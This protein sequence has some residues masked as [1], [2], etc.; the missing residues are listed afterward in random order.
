M[1]KLEFCL[2][3]VPA[4]LTLAGCATLRTHQ[5]GV[6]EPDDL[7][8]DSEGAKRAEALANY[9]Q[10]Q[11]HEVH[12]RSEDALRHYERALE[13]DPTRTRLA[14]GM[15][16]H[17]LRIGNTEKATELLETAHAS[18]P[19]SYELTRALATLYANA[20]RHEEA[21][22]TYKQA[23]R[24]RRRDSEPYIEL[25]RY[26]M[27]QRDER[28]ALR[29]LDRGLRRVRDPIELYRALADI[30]MRKVVQSESEQQ[31]TDYTEVIA[32]Y[33]RMVQES[34][35]DDSIN[36]QLGELYLLNG[37]IPEAIAAFRK[38]SDEKPGYFFLRAVTRHATGRRKK[39][40]DLLEKAAPLLD[41]DPLVALALGELSEDG[42]DTQKAIRHFERARQIAPKQMAAYVRLA[43]LY[44]K[45][46][47]DKAAE[48]LSKAVQELPDDPQPRIY[49][50]YI[51]SFAKDYPGAIAEFEKA[52]ALLSGKDELLVGLGPMFYFWY[53]AACEREKQ[54]ERAEKLFEKCI[55]L[56]P[57]QDEAYNYLAYMWAERAVKLDQAL[58]YV[59][60]AL[61][62]Q[63]ENGAY[64]D[65]LG[66][67]YYQRK[68][69]EKAREQ[70]LKAH[71]LMKN[72]PTIAD[73]L[74][75]VLL[76]LEGPSQA[77]FFWEK[78]LALDPKNER[79]ADKIA[80]HKAAG[81]QA[82]E[83]TDLG[84]PPI[85][86]MLDAQEQEPAPDEPAGTGP[87]FEEL[88]QPDGGLLPEQPD[89]GDP[90][91]P[92]LPPD[93]PLPGKP[94]LEENTEPDRREE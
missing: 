66:W 36:Y 93:S 70:L 87:Q 28:M 47:P 12:N 3:A 44:A 83:P 82:E 65:T 62:I 89:E 22:R 15:A 35:D 59:R 88:E 48:V 24:Y 14:I 94:I 21:V 51:K 27:K 37:Q 63:P 77:L 26:Y 92:F 6:G 75:D 41:K 86:E 53:G 39:I 33:E 80:K 7:A 20:D 32:V 49:L 23:I 81:H 56:D 40:I 19:K 57:E 54:I 52:A 84:P 68:E 64:I 17:Y 72:D 9:A 8:L 67:I 11:I 16:M 71:Q 58:D 10:G 79:V 13:L 42:G 4:A 1:R 34:P 55:A 2:L 43:L 46:K 18:D 5:A 38:V 91:E 31:E 45:D 30:R 61:A 76:E 50:G 78:S 60:K 25:A 69:Y 29:T 74:G 85:I 73:H 90:G